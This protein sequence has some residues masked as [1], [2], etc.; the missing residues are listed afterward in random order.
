MAHLHYGKNCSKLV[1]LKEQNKYRIYKRP[2]LEQNL[3]KCKHRLHCYVTIR[4]KTAY[5]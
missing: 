1:G 5:A 4:S 3:L 2:R